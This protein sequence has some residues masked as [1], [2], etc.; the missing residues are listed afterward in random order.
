MPA[1]T[2]TMNVSLTD[3]LRDVV[4]ERLR[5]GL[6]GNASEYVRELI[7]RDEEAARQLRSLYQVGIDSGESVAMSEG[8]WAALRSVARSPASGQ[9]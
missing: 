8:D 7:R 6:Y 5:S 1:K 4:D 2:P 3:A 9:A